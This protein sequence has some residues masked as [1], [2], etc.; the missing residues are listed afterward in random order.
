MRGGSGLSLVLCPVLLPSRRFGVC[1]T[2]DSGR[3]PG[4]VHAD[5]CCRCVRRRTETGTCGHSSMS[6]TCLDLAA[7]ETWTGDRDRR[8][9]EGEQTTHALPGACRALIQPET[10]PSP[11][12]ILR[13]C[14]ARLLACRAHENSGLAP[15]G[16]GMKART[17]PSESMFADGRLRLCSTR[18]H[19]QA[20]GARGAGILWS[21]TSF[22]V[23][24][25]IRGF[26]GGKD[27][28]R[29]C[30]PTI[31][32]IRRS[33]GLCPNIVEVQQMADLRWPR[34]WRPSLRG[35][36]ETKKGPCIRSLVSGVWL[37]SRALLSVG[38]LSPL[39][40]SPCSG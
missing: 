34:R 31:V 26:R 19:L 1:H 9:K 21:I 39:N 33:G 3:I 25:S 10:D 20:K 2:T 7:R 12:R 32:A 13:P 14:F 4:V 27:V 6:T 16:R 36:E 40:K 38:A 22:A 24:G 23:H 11:S 28:P 30:W 37:S 18:K 15:C 35:A 5:T 29:W 8:K 17:G